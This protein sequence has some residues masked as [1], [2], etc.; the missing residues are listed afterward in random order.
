MPFLDDLQNFLAPRGRKRKTGRI[1]AIG[2][3]VVEGHEIAVG[4]RLLDLLAKHLRRGT[5]IVH[6]HTVDGRPLIQA[7]AR[8]ETRIG[9][10]IGDIGNLL[11][12]CSNTEQARLI[13]PV[14]PIVGTRH[15]G[16]S[17]V[18]SPCHIPGQRSP[19]SSVGRAYRRRKRL[20]AAAPAASPDHSALRRCA[21]APDRRLRV[22]ETPAGR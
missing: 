20:R 4:A 1:V 21:R 14:A 22:R 7:C 10:C 5:F 11:G 12:D 18:P 9:R 3:R 16:S 8:H 15:S 2:H 6:F 17:S 19:G 13:P